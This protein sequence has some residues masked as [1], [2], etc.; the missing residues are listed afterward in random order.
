MK[1]WA[2]IQFE[3]KRDE[4]NDKLDMKIGAVIL[5]ILFILLFCVIWF[6]A[7][8]YYA[9]AERGTDNTFDTIIVSDIENRINQVRAENGLNRFEIDLCLRNVAK[10]RANEMY[11]FSHTRPNGEY[12]DTAN[13]CGFKYAG[14]NLGM[15]LKESFNVVKEW[16][17]SESHKEVLLNPLYS[18]MGFYQLGDYYVL[19]LTN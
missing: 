13:K 18:K 17:D 6:R 8:P 2:E 1:T 4:M 3:K 11:E 16:L 12:F 19:E 15:R 9:E 7:M 5:I 10:I 14:E